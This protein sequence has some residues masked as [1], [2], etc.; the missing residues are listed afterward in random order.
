MHDPED[1]PVWSHAA[2][3]PCAHGADLDGPWRADRGKD[4]AIVGCGLL[5][6]GGTLEQNAI[7]CGNPAFQ[8]LIPGE[9]PYSRPDAWRACPCFRGG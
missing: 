1:D 9:C 4:R 2:G 7:A 5:T 3:P 6:R 8:P